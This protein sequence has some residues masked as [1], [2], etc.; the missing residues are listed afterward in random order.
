ML[1]CQR[2]SGRRKLY[3]M[4]NCYSLVDCGGIEVTCPLCLGEGEIKSL[5]DAIEDVKEKI[6]EEEKPK[7][8]YEKKSQSQFVFHPHQKSLNVETGAIE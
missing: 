8:K 2:C 5:E 6:S 1:R 7:R 3:K 4:N